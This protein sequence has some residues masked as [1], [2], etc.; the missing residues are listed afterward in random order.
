MQEAI[1]TFGDQRLLTF[2]NDPQTR[3]PTIEVAHEALIR[4][5]RRLREW[6]DAAREDL[7]TQRRLF[8]STLEWMNADRDPS[9]LTS[10]TRL[11][12]FEGLQRAANVA[13]N[14]DETAYVAASVA[15]R[16]ARLAQEAERKAREEALEARAQRRLQ[17]LVIGTSLAAMVALAL[18]FF[19]VQA[20][21]DAVVAQAA[22]EEAAITAQEREA[23]AK[24][25][26]LAA[27]ALTLVDNYRPTL[28]LVLALE[29]AS[30][31]PDLTS[32][33]QALA[34]TAYSPSA[35]AQLNPLVGVSLVSVSFNADGTRVAAGSADGQLL[36]LDPTTRETRIAVPDAHTDA[37]GVAVAVTAVD[38]S[39]SG[40]TIASGDTTGTIKLWDAATGDLIDSWDAHTER[41]TVLHFGP[42]GERVLSGSNDTQ[43]ILWDALTG[44]Q[45][46]TFDGHVGTIFSADWAWEAGLVVS[47]T[48]DS[49]M[50]DG[51]D[52]RQVRVYD[53]ETGEQVQ[54]FVPGGSG[55]LR[56]TAITPDGA[57]VAVASYDPNAF[58][59]TIRLLDV[60]TGLMQQ[61][62]YGHTDVITTLDISRDGQR[63]ISG[64]WDQTV[65]VWDLASGARL[66][67]FDTQTDRILMARFDPVGDHALVAVGRDS[68]SPVDSRTLYYRLGTLAL[69]HTLRGHTDWLWSVGYS[70]DGNLLATG[71][72]HLNTAE[73]D[74]SVRLWDT[75]T[76]AELAVIQGHDNTVNGVDFHPTEAI[77]ASGAWDGRVRLW[78]VTDP[79]APEPLAVLAEYETA[80]N[81]VDFG[82]N[83]EVLLS[84]GGD[85]KVV[86]YN[87]AN[88]EVVRE[89]EAHPGARVL[90]AKF[91]P[92]GT[93]IASS[94]TD[95]TVRV[96]NAR[97]GEMVRELEGH[98]GW[99]NTVNFDPTGELIVSGADNNLIIWDLT[100][101]EGDEIY[102]MLVGHKGFV[103]GGDFSP[104][105]QYVI[106]VA[107]DTSVR[108]WEV[109]TG[110]EIRRFDDH[111]NW[112]LD[113][114]FHPDG[115]SATS[116]AEDNTARIWEIAPSTDVLIAWAAE[117]RYVPEL[118]CDQREQYD[119][120]PLCD[121]LAEGGAG[122]RREVRSTSSDDVTD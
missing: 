65:R 13:M 59:G 25:V 122:R 117:N 97:T 115:T 40:E 23:E 83:G 31:R 32:V 35:L 101:P 5:W 43:L 98:T 71:S 111:T 21:Q 49:P 22:A 47:S 95:S 116:V 63:L 86:M 50:D 92:D 88:N 107:S 73:G 6:L 36:V 7:R 100:A 52:D 26:A 17:W 9:Y 77:L 121:T 16:D 15:A 102:R 4:E 68:G 14:E 3:E 1:N 96:W 80:V 20:Q 42:D 34:A 39:V 113:V 82:P 93:L 105:G 74:N 30:R 85:G 45:I 56:A 76:G 118:T 112:V 61:G 37:E 67:R 27:N 60:Q 2:D 81:D 87:L 104:E 114:E 78:N 120:E 119:V 72:G 69:E 38:Y 62:L 46:R 51:P 75:A 110:A 84:A 106:S 55:W 103:Y 89:I 8:Q 99:V 28:G 24:A 58:G 66:H 19:A 109:A 108:L 48:G 90:R 29:A 94:G 11:E 18:A 70:P 12:Q 33:Q 57:T 64:G 53:V 41:V 10:G 54:G 79:A 44:E 91:S